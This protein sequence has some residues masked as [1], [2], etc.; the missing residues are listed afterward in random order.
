MTERRKTEIK[1]KVA[2]ESKLFCAM[3]SN[4]DEVPHLCL[5]TGGRGH[6]CPRRCGTHG[7]FH[8]KCRRTAEF[9]TRS[10]QEIPASRRCQ[11]DGTVRR[12][13]GGTAAPAAAA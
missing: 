5:N 11:T 13:R 10:N 12:E 7:G 9:Q 1:K 4:R 6:P 8:I 3:T 2:K